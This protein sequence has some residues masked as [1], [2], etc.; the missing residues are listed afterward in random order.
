MTKRFYIPAE[1]PDV[2]ALHIALYGASVLAKEYKSEIILIVPT[3]KHASGTILSKVLKGES[4]KKLVKG[5][6]LKYD[7]APIR[8][9]S[10]QT[11]DPYRDNGV[12]V[13]LWA[14]NNMLKKIDQSDDAI[15]VLALRWVGSEVE[16]WASKHK[17]TKLQDSS[18]QN[19]E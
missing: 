7:N 1:G 8:M 4:L 10:T 3:L 13:A 12:L 18:P 19:A 16:D 14:G 6:S 5:A 9:V 11:F 15:G 2:K 17:A